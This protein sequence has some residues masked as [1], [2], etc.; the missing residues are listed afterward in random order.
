VVLCC[1]SFLLQLEA[2]LEFD[3]L[4]FRLEAVEE[5]EEAAGRGLIR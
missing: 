1:F 4:L 5:E 3:L 2:L